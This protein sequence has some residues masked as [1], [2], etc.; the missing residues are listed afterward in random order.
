MNQTEIKSK[1]KDWDRHSRVILLLQEKQ[2]TITEL[3]V[4]IGEYIQSVS[5]CL[6]GIPGRRNPRI[7]TKVAEFLGVGR[8]ELFGAA[9]KQTQR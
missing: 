8:E 5:A 7:E 1:V 2:M 9:V 4:S 3:S 6:W